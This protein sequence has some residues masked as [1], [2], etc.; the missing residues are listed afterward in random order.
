M[1]ILITT[2]LLAVLTV[3]AQAR[4]FTNQKGRTFDATLLSADALQA[5]LMGAD[6]KKY[7]IVIAT[8]SEADQKFCRDWVAANP[9]LKLTVKA[10]GFRAKGSRDEKDG[11]GR[12]GDTSTSTRSQSAQEGYR[13]TVSNWSSNPGAKVSGL[14]VEYAIVVGYTDT[15]AKDRRGVKHISRGSVS[16]P[17]LTGSRPQTVE[18]KTVTTRQSASV[19]SRTER[20]SDGDSRTATSA[21]LYRESMDGVF[22]VIKHGKRVVATH[23]TGKVPQELQTEMTKPP[24]E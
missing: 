5:E 10:E 17:E 14:T 11:Q 24:A 1:R 15:K 9:Q 21:A 7:K 4:T 16:L 6:G 8:L 23:S 3:G 2:A 20:D 12:S 18:T 22:L 19:S 13:I